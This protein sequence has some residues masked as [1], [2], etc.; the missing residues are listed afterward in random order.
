M[1]PIQ[2]P[3][4]QASTALYEHPACHTLARSGHPRATKLGDQRLTTGCRWPAAKKKV[5][6]LHAVRSSIARETTSSSSDSLTLLWRRC[7]R[8]AILHAL[9]ANSYIERPDT[10][11]PQPAYVAQGTERDQQT[12]GPNRSGLFQVCFERSYSFNGIEVLLSPAF[13]ECLLTSTGSRQHFVEGRV[14]AQALQ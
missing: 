12:C 13:F 5:A 4:Q 10:G 6:K 8:V 9:C 1:I 7:S 14:L 3:S 2:A 11:T